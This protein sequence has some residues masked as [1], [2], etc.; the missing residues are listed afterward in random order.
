MMG[1]YNGVIVRVAANVPVAGS[2]SECI[3]FG[4]E[5]FARGYSYLPDWNEEEQD[6]GF[7]FGVST[8][9]CYDDARAVEA[10]TAVVECYAAAPVA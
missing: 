8:K 10:N 2:K 7:I 1:V 9:V 5:A 3:A 4:G 6:Y